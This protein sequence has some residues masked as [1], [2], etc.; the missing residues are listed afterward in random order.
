MI[1]CGSESEG[2]EVSTSAVSFP[3]FFYASSGRIGRFVSVPG[4]K[5]YGRSKV[6]TENT[7]PPAGKIFS[8][9][10]RPDLGEAEQPDIP[11]H[12]RT[13][14]PTDADGVGW[15]RTMK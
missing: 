5:G 11:S 14:W 13:E 4:L 3:T 12:R 1:L 2:V 6:L 15:W 10:A 9:T 7:S 8:Q